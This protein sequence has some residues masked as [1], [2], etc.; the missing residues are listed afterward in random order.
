[1]NTLH[2]L[3]PGPL[4]LVEDLGRPGHAHLGVTASG[5]LDRGALRLANRLVG[6]P[7]GAAGLEV[8]VGGL[9]VRFGGG[10]WFAL[11]GAWGDANLVGDGRSM[12]VRPS[13]ATF[14]DDGAVLDIP[15]A[16]HGLR[17]L[18]A[19]RG[20]IDVPPV[21]ESRSAD[22]LSGLGPG[23]LAAGDV[24]R[25]GPE[26]EQPPPP[27][28]SL[29]VWSPPDGV[30][31]VALLPGPRTD[32]L[33]ESSRV[34]LYEQ[35]WTVSAQS[36]RVGARLEGEPLETVTSEELPSEG[37]VAGAMQLPPSGQPTVLLADHPVTG[38]YPVI[39]V[40]ADSALDAFAQLRPGQSVRFRHR[41]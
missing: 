28:D 24:I 18:F 20:G 30:V 2:V 39:A 15:P 33:T 26:P 10:S 35:L 19:V 37:M 27:A 38:G 7:E 11:S 3:E 23:V 25:I 21:L 17:Y 9:R 29:T 32:R 1:M 14:A 41:P 8:T 22:T 40:V 12:P 13:F 5:T 31:E 6:N 4:T 34:R 36:N 16:S